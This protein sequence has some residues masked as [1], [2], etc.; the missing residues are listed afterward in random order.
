[1]NNYAYHSKLREIKLTIYSRKISFFTKLANYLHHNYDCVVVGN[2][3]NRQN[4]AL[5]GK[6]PPIKTFLNFAFEKQI[7]INIQ[8]E[9]R[10]SMLCH[11]C[12][13]KLANFNKNTKSIDESMKYSSL[14]ACVSETCTAR[15]GIFI[16]DRDKNATINIGFKYLVSQKVRM[17][18]SFAR[19]TSIA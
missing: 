4:S 9:F 10:T 12:H 14:K 2:W 16:L 17:A 8:D 18:I 3:Y 15:Q 6:R 1:L 13:K 11:Q 19:E 5:K 7:P